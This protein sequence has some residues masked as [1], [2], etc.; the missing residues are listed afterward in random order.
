MFGSIPPLG[1]NSSHLSFMIDW[2][3]MNYK[4]FNIFPQFIWIN[5]LNF[6]VH[7]KVSKLFKHTGSRPV[8]ILSVCTFNVSYWHFSITN[9]EI[10]DKIDVGIAMEHLSC[11]ARWCFTDKRFTAF[12]FHFDSYLFYLNI[13]IWQDYSIIYCVKLL[14]KI[15]SVLYTMIIT[16]FLR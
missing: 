9:K 6:T 7:W 15:P 13:K 5:F 4:Y 2:A 1:I 8:A 3:K 14:S 12:L 16:N 10:A 11:V